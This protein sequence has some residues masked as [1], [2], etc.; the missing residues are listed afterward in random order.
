MSTISKISGTAISAISKLSGALK[1]NTLYVNTSGPGTGASPAIPTG[2]I[3]TNLYSH[4]D[5]GSGS[6]VP[7]H[8]DDLAYVCISGINLR[9]AL[10]GAVYSSE[11]SGSIYFDGINDRAIND[12]NYE[13]Y[14]GG[15]QTEQRTGIDL[16]GD[17]TLGLWIRSL[18]LSRFQVIY[19]LKDSTTDGLSIN[20]SNSSGGVYRG[21]INS[22]QPETPV[23]N[24][25][26]FFYVVTTYKASTQTVSI[27]VNGV[28]EAS[29]SSAG[30][31]NVLEEKTVIGGDSRGLNDASRYFWNGYLSQAQLYTSTFT[32]A[33]VLQNFNAHKERYGY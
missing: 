33:Q 19:N 27:Y 26:D 9:L 32:A 30:S 2:F 20:Q 17:A 22:T 11:G 31:L 14:F 1:S 12:V 4:F 7:G 16:V 23:I 5:I 29:L 18:D 15:V 21:R 25:T 3:T 13:G 28:L 10:I 6:F 24:T 8:I